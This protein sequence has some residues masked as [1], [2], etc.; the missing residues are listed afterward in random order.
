M[1]DLI[2]EL[3]SYDEKRASDSVE[4]A[5]LDSDEKGLSSENDA[6]LVKK[7]EAMEDRIQHDEATEDEYLV[8]NPYDVA[9]KVV[10]FPLFSHN[11]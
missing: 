1:A 9:L 4:K 3:P 2:A 8:Q 11:F 10:H 6:E 5:S 7:V